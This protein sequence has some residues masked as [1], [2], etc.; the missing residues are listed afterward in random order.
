MT[1]LSISI[2]AINVLADNPTKLAGFWSEVTG[3][4][5]HPSH[6][7]VYLAPDNPSGFAMFFRKSST[8]LWTMAPSRTHVDLT[9]PYGQR[10]STVER[11]IDL[12]AQGLWSITDEHPHV[13]WTTMKDPE[14]NLFCIAE[15]PPVDTY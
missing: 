11:L 2:G 3:G 6:D 1:N 13:Q 10:E 4:T 7:D 9:V 14:G 5:T 12:G 8:P 15:H